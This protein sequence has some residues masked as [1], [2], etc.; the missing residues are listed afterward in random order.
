NTLQ[1]ADEIGIGID[2]MQS[3]GD[4]QTLND[5]Y[6]FGAEL[7]PV[8]R[9][10]VDPRKPKRESRSVQRIRKG[11]EARTDTFVQQKS[12][13]FRPM[14]MARTARLRWLVSVGRGWPHAVGQVFWILKCV[15][16]AG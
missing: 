9:H 11:G 7:R 1:N 10:G 16:S 2:P 13:A 4:E 5:P 6:V 8:A 14:G 12:H 3:A 15:S